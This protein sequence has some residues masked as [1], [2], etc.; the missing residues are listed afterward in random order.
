MITQCFTTHAGVVG[1]L[2]HLC[3]VPEIFAPSPPPCNIGWRCWASAFHT[4]NITWGRGEGEVWLKERGFFLFDKRMMVEACHS[5]RESHIHVADFWAGYT[6]FYEAF[7]FPSWEAAAQI[8]RTWDLT[9]N[10]DRVLPQI[11]AIWRNSAQSK[12]R[13]CKLCILCSRFSR[14]ISP[15]RAARQVT[16][17][18]NITPPQRNGPGWDFCTDKPQTSRAIEYPAEFPYFSSA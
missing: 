2:C 9:L 1:T 12:W 14:A 16:C 6:I 15:A 11:D 8:Y 18:E 5:A 10:T 7:F 3:I 4:S 17:I 13:L